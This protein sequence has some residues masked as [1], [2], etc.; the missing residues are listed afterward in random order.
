MIT[1]SAIR[2]ISTMNTLDICPEYWRKA[3]TRW[4]AYIGITRWGAADVS[5]YDKEVKRPN[6]RP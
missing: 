3:C 5:N 2:P 6:S 4:M 1:D